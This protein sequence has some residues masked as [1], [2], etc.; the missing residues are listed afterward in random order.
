M[1]SQPCVDIIIVN[2]HS[3]ND[4]K[5]CLESLGPWPYGRIVLV[6]NSEDASESDALRQLAMGRP[7]VELL[8]PAQNLGFG[9]GCNLAFER[10]RA[11]YV[12][13]LNPD[14]L[15]SAKEVVTLAR[16][17]DSS[18]T[19]GAVS[20]RIYWNAERS[21]LLPI[22][23]PQSPLAELAMALAS[24]S[25]R[26]TRWAAGRY[27]EHARQKMTASTPF[28]VDF[29]AGAVMMLRRHAVLRAGGLFDPDYFMFFEDSDLSVRLRRAGY[30]LAMVPSA[31]AVHEY[32]HKAF[33][34]ELMAQSQQTYFS[35]RFPR[36]HA[37][38]RKLKLV[39]ALAREIDP[40]DWF[41]LA[42][43]QVSSGADFASQTGSAAVLA[44][45]PSLLM[46]PAMFIPAWGEALNF[47]EAEWALLEPA[48]YVAL[49]RR[50]AG[51]QRTDWVHFQ[52]MP[53]PSPLINPEAP[54]S[55]KS[56]TRSKPSA[57]P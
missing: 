48:S 53:E 27:V 6:D 2:Y 44:V 17:L 39:G 25:A 14:A 23:F 12:L 8:T 36:F 24:R 5:R 31:S 43:L 42:N 33:K 1:C 34:A 38:S 13:L 37:W 18:P 28:E 49:I 30:T 15:I 4:I 55:H 56:S 41:A 40:A 47:S 52:R 29:L 45:S 57:L 51:P 26:V 20:P 32:R 19:L 35:K 11:E 46:R 54:S 22:A 16:T 7:E 3:A 50:E 10:C 21:F 9:R